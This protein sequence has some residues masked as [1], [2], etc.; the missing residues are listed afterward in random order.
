M[1]DDLSPAFTVDR[2]IGARAGIEMVSAATD[3]GDAMMHPDGAAAEMP[4]LID[5]IASRTGSS[6]DAA[7]QLL[8]N[9]FPAINGFLTSLPLPEVSAELPKL[10]HYLSTVLQQTPAQT[11]QM[12]QTD[13]P[14]IW[15]VYQNLPK[16][17]A[18]WDAIP[19]TE[20]LTRFDGTPVRT[21]PQLRTYLSQEV[22][23]PVE[24]QQANFRPLG[25]RGGVW[26][27]PPLLLVLG[28][29]V[30]AFGVAMI[31]KTRNGV[32]RNRLRYAWAVVSVIGVIVPG[33]V[34]A[35]NLF[36]RLIGGQA[37]LDDTRPVFALDR[38]QGDHAGVEF[39]SIFVDALGPAVLPDGGVTQEYPALLEHV[40][41]HVGI[42][43]QDVRGLVHLNFPHAAR[44]LDGVPFS[45]STADATTL[46]NVLASTSHVTSERVLQ[47][48]KAQLPQ[49]YQLITSLKTVTDGWTEVP[50][51]E[52]LTHFDGTPSRSVPLIRDYFRNDVI[53]G[54]ERQQ[55][56]FVIVDTNWPQLI[57]FA[58]LLC[59]LG[60]A[61][62]VYGFLIRSL[63]S[64]LLRAQGE[65]PSPL[66]PTSSPPI[67]ADVS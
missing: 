55:P 54:L 42:P 19:G 6:P 66:T 43:L 12:L 50:G 56:H 40:A 64:K 41:Q 62:F 52:N 29:A 30:I 8:R 2:V 17:T 38:I 36:P 44:L 51:T 15:Q 23:G 13:Y 10:V 26:F 47:D 5:F 48:M 65:P 20:A 35:L 22:V 33:L 11:D 34:L 32:K 57:I 4:R 49:T 58:P 31:V 39:I 1:V 16:L 45:A 63:T 25:A 53:P 61:V 60:A 7:Q 59:A 9:D 37:L 14:K 46:I 3:T 24:R 28:A 21:M 27:L 18:G 67:P